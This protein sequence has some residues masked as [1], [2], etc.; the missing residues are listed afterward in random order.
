MAVRVSRSRFLVSA[1][2]KRGITTM[3]DGSTILMLQVRHKTL[4]EINSTMYRIVKLS[5]MVIMPESSKK[6]PSN[7]LFKRKKIRLQKYMTVD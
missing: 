6:N 7:E 3:G 2:T 1:S 5:V 4:A